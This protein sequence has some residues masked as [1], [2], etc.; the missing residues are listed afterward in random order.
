MLMSYVDL[1]LALFRGSRWDSSVGRELRCEPP[2]VVLL[3]STTKT[4]I[5]CRLPIISKYRAL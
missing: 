4:I 3:P 2:M 5:F 1:P